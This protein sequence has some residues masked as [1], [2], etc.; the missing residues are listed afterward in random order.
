M[1]KKDKSWGKRVKEGGGEARWL[2][3]KL[4]L[5]SKAGNAAVL[6]E[7][8]EH[9][10]QV[11]EG[12]GYVGGVGHCHWPVGAVSR[13]SDL[14]TPATKHHKLPNPENSEF[15]VLLF[16][17]LI[18]LMWRF[19]AQL[20]SFLYIRLPRVHTHTHTPW[21]GMQNSQWKLS[22]ISAAGSE[23]SVDFV[24][25]KSEKTNQ[26]ESRWAEIKQGGGVGGVEGVG[27]L[28]RSIPQPWPQKHTCRRYCC[29]LA[30]G[31]QRYAN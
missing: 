27:G 17:L 10:G 13:S 8:D 30:S 23:R 26:R 6:W 20:D 22:H 1:K 3:G 29:S 19:A 4:L 24:R 16:F 18:L 31:A 14:A 5:H 12:L 2:A 11:R 28:N 9:W 7:D 15:S 25:W 21:Y